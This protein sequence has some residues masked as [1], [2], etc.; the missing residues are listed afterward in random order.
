MLRYKSL[1]TG[2]TD[3]IRPYVC[4]QGSLVTLLGAYLSDGLVTISNLAV[5]KAGLVVSLIIAFGF[6]TND[7]ID[8]SVDSISKPDRAIPSGKVSRQMAFTLAIILALIAVFLAWTLSIILLIITI[9]NIIL[10]ASYSI[11][12]KNT[13]LLGNLTIAL[14]NGSIVIFGSLVV[15]GP[16][17]IVWII[18][19]L[20]FL[21]TSAQE[22]LYTVEDKTGDTL[23]GLRTTAIRLGASTTLHLF[24]VLAISTLIVAIVPWV[25]H[26]TGNLYMYTLVP[27][28]ILPVIGAIVLVTL[29]P[30]QLNIHRSA[31]IMRL[32]RYATLLPILLV[33][34]P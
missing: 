20:S 33:K 15:S 21:Y 23:A 30:N 3:L 16:S 28:S 8:V 19:L 5:I 31:K 1:L 9:G 26:L 12:L 2:L 32:A 22:T 6:V 13:L 34:F 25:L 10:S 4:L 18:S 27:C 14:L 17:P 7:Y 29:D 24:R 11:F